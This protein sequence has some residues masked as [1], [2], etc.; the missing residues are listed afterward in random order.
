MVSSPC[1]ASSSPSRLWNRPRLPVP[2]GSGLAGG[3]PLQGQSSASWFSSASTLARRGDLKVG[4]ELQFPGLAVIHKTWDDSGCSTVVE[5]TLGNREVK[6]SNLTFKRK[7]VKKKTDQRTQRHSN[8]QPFSLLTAL[9][10]WYNSSWT[11]NS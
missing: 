1:C 6:G 11:F 5:D 8:P 3:G 9:P 10:L 4:K 7:I 2:G